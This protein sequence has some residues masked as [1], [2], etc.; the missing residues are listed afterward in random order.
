VK[1]EI[2]LFYPVVAQDGTILAAYFS[3]DV[4]QF[5]DNALSGMGIKSPNGTF[6]K[7]ALEL[8]SE[9][10][11]Q[12]A[13]FQAKANFPLA[14]FMPG[15]GTTRLWYNQIAS[16]IASNGYIVVTIDSPYDPDGSFALLNSTLWDSSNTTVQLHTAYVGIESQVLDVSFVLDQL[17][18][19]TLA[20]TLIPN[21]PNSGLNTT[22]AMFGHSLGGSTAYSILEQ[23]ARILGG[24]DMDGGLFGPG[25]GTS[26]PFMIM[27]CA[28]HTRDF[29][30]D[31]TQISWAE[32]WPNIT[33]WRRELMV[34]V[35]LPFGL[36]PGHKLTLL[37]V[38]IRELCTTTSV[39]TL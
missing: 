19:A 12:D 32:A 38:G 31:P 1:L 15:E 27:G 33:G 4:A 26:K 25:D 3:E 39:T 5:E 37:I 14:I 6:A 9:G 8:A 21:L 36:H 20:H 16:T 29:D 24:L 35:R 23:D 28:N 10:A 2:S 13:S 18:N 34:A 22:T 7:L 11:C 30:G 17:S